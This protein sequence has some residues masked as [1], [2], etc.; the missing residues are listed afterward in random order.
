MGKSVWTYTGYTWEHLLAE[1]NP[2]RVKLLKATDV[3]VDGRFVLAER[4]LELSFRGSRNQRLID[5]GASL[6]AGAVVA[7]ERQAYV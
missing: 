4:S 6:A 7:Y 1:A 3:L 5:V 2:T